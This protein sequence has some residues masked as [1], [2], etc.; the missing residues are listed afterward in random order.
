[1]TLENQIALVTGGSR[2]IGRLTALAL[3]ARG[4]DVVLTYR[5]EAELA[6]SAVGEIEEM[7]RR[8]AAFQVDFA[9]TDGIAPL[10][11]FTRERM[12]DWG[13]DGLDILVNNAGAPSIGVP[14]HVTADALDLMFAINFRAPFLLTQELLGDLKDGAR[15]VN[16]SSGLAKKAFPPLIAYGPMKGAVETWTT[17]LAQA[18]GGRGI[19]VNAVS[20][21]GLD[22]DFNA[23]LFDKIAPGARD[24]VREATALGR[25]GVPADVAGV[26]AFLASPESGFI[27]GQS[28]GID[29]GFKL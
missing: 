15:I 7:G 13:H 24:Y 5:N 22:D 27:T 11:A 9:G 21:G 26:I 4:A 28:L 23:E 14:G 10:A 3:A 2:N 17:N 18:L 6:A 16:L 25:I 8:A 29:G 20:P 1:M 19:R 12:A